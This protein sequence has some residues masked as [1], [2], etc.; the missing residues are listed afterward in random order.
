MLKNYFKIALRNLGRHKLFSFINIFGLALSMSVCMMVMVRVK[1]ELSYDKFHPQPGRTYRILSEVKNNKGDQ[2][3]LASTPLPLKQELLQQSGVIADAVHL[4]PAI[5]HKA[6][7]GNKL[8]N[9]RGAF[10]EP[11][12]FRVFGFT[13]ESGD[14]QTALQ[15]PNGIVLSN[16]AAKKFFS[17]ESAVGKVLTLDKLG[18]FV[19]TGV[20]NKT[21]KSHIDYDVYVSTA[22]LPQLE[23]SGALATRSSSWDSFEF[24]YT[25]ILLNKN[26]SQKQLSTVLNNIVTVINR[27]TKGGSFAFKAQP[28]ND[29][30]PS[31]M[32]LGNTIG[33]G[34]DWSKVW[35]EIGVA[36]LILIAACFNYTNLTIARALTRAKEV[37]IRKVAGAVRMQVF[38][39][40]IIESIVIALFALALAN[41]FLQF[42]LT[43]KPFNDGYEFVPIISLDFTTFLWF[44]LFALVTGAIAGAAPAWI[45]S[46]FKP[47]Q[48]LK[49]IATHKLFGNVSMQRVLIVFQ[50]SL[51]LIIIIFLSAFFRQFTYMATVDTGFRKDNIVTINLEG[52]DP[53]LVA[54]EARRL[55]GVEN[56]TAIS[57]NFGRHATGST[58]AWLDKSKTPIRLNF[59][60][61]DA[62]SIPAMDLKLIAG[63]N[64]PATASQHS[65]RYIIVNETAAK[66]FGF[67]NNAEAINKMIW[68]NDTLEVQ[69]AGVI[70]DFYY[71]GAGNRISPMAIRSKADVYNLLNVQSSVANDEKL[72]AQL[73]SAWKKLYPGKPF[74]YYWLGKQ[75]EE[76][77]RQN[78][79]VSLLGFLAFMTICIASLGLLGLVIY[80]VETRRKEI[81]IRKVIGASVQQLTMLLS[82]GFIKLLF[83]AGCIAMPL[84]YVL[85]FFFLQNFA[86]RISLGAG[87]L[88]SCFAFLLAIGLF[89]II[90]QT[91]KAASANPVEKLKAE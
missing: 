67:S 88:L 20:L 18:S 79:S 3:H 60:Y 69:I 36:L 86:N 38:M 47:V 21:G 82:K 43:Y 26:A 45:L 46:A 50:F 10:T 57:T 33:R 39:Q 59:Y 11:S 37:G 58:Y 84:G 8:I 2:F 30:T 15:S 65:E 68:L 1:D 77:H 54:N 4:Y 5:D 49:N 40:Y 24:G 53:V 78:S 56:A 81:S 74:N 29:I 72:V 71:Q 48:V 75:I 44:L 66:A 31:S 87:W 89:T 14:K 63:N 7:Y 9:V 13:L 22:A 73:E 25:Y 83:I 91:W 12:F 80:T 70:K 61:G 19:V 85:S 17:D 6:T 52:A 35:T 64:L 28:L 42:I 51:S 27:D 90:S 23:K 16:D 32:N 55:P 62:S 34:S 76:T 41:V